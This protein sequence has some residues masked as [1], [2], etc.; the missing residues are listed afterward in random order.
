MKMFFNVFQNSFRRL[1]DYLSGKPVPVACNFEA[2]RCSRRPSEMKHK[3]IECIGMLS[4]ANSF[5]KAPFRHLC[6][7]FFRTRKRRDNAVAIP[8][9]SFEK[10]YGVYNRTGNHSTVVALFPIKH[11]DPFRRCFCPLVGR[12]ITRYPVLLG[13]SL[14]VS[15]F[16]IASIGLLPFGIGVQA[17]SLQEMQRLARIGDQH[18]GEKQ[19]ELAI[20]DYQQ[21]LSFGKSPQLYYNL[22]QTYASLDQP[23]FALACFLK[24]ETLKPCWD[25]NKKALT[26]LYEDCPMLSKPPFPWYHTTYRTLSKNVWRW[27]CAAF[28]W[29]SAGFALY[30]C[31]VR[32]NKAALSG[33]VV[34]C[35]CFVAILTFLLVNRPYE[36]L[37]LL[38]K[39][40]I[41]HYAPGD[42]SPMRYDWS[43]G[44]C[45]QIRSETA[46]FYFISTLN[47]E[48]GWVRKDELIPLN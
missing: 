7:C 11:C 40:T 37:F 10:G 31:V 43:A 44:T 27:C 39:Q 42:K 9:K 19:F 41:G 47:Q 29:L 22:G 30:H 4:Q 18:F 28:F 8:R 23:G 48:D 20:K 32:K 17:G 21:A 13:C 45:C 34:C 24:A 6:G 2:I 25:L 12:F 46:D 36:S 26:E 5:L 33:A 1:K 16:I 38:P 15:S 35:G 14:P 3:S